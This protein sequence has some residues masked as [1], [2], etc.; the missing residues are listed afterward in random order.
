MT[1]ET[2]IGLVTPLQY[3]EDKFSYILLKYFDV[4]M[5]NWLVRIN[6]TNTY[7]GLTNEQFEIWSD[8]E[9]FKYILKNYKTTMAKLSNEHRQYIDSYLSYRTSLIRHD[10]IALEFVLTS[11]N[12]IIRKIN[13]SKEELMT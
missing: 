5:S 1:A 2:I 11:K 7:I 9:W 12:G 6:D 3:R 13:F 10:N 8:D 4:N